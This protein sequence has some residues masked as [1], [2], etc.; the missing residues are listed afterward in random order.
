MANWRNGAIN[1][2]PIGGTTPAA[3]A[4]TT[5][6]ATSL[7]DLSAAGA[8]Q[9][10]FPA[11]Q[12]ASS[13]ANTLDDYEEGTWTPSFTSLSVVAGG[14]SV[15]YTGKYTKIGNTVYWNARINA[16]GGATTA[17]TAGTTFI[18]NMPFDINASFDSNCVACTTGTVTSL[19]IGVGG[20]GAD[21]MFTPTWAATTESILI[22]G[23]FFV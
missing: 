10:K 16:T 22:S 13:N 6:S 11:T 12:N 21:N 5:L 15:T 14:G 1:G 4:F 23:F 17:S 7:T 20:P 2:V 3:G 9:V 18:T 8:G 19:G